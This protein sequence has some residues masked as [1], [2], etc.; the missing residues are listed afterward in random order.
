MTERRYNYLFKDMEL[1]LKREVFTDESTI[2]K[3]TIDG[4]MECYIL[5]DKDRGLSND[6]PLSEIVATK[7][8]GKTCIP[9]GRYE[10]DWTM[11]A[12]FKKMMPILLN[13]SG[14]SRIRIHV[15]NAE[16]DSLGCLLPC[17]KYSKNLGIA[18]T[19][20]TTKLYTKI[21]SAKKQGQKIFITITK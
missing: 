4:V 16:K 18:S 6:M 3:L 15:G 14:Y 12:R 5:E 21:E 2:G 1:V 20:A 11:S 9:Y 13:V 19:V 7:V 17:S 10:I 8:Y